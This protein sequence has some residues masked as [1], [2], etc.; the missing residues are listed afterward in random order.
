MIAF[1]MA[2]IVAVAGVLPL[3]VG[4]KIVA[5]VVTSA[6]FF[7]ILWP[8]FYAANPSLV[9]PLGGLLS[10]FLLLCWVTSAIVDSILDDELR[11][12]WLFAIGLLVIIIFRAGSGCSCFRASEYAKLIGDFEE[13]E[14]TQDVQPASAEHIRLVPWELA[15][16]LADKQLGEAPGAIGSQFSVDK[17]RATIQ[18]IRGEFWWVMPLDYNGFTVWTSVDNAPGYVLV[19]ADDPK[20][21]PILKYQ[22]KFVFTPGAYFGDNLE[23]HLWSNGYLAKGLDDAFLEIDEEG[24][25]WWVV[26]VFKPTIAYSGEKLLGIAMVDPENGN[27]SF[28]EKD[29]IPEWIDRAIPSQFIRYYI[30]KWGELRNGW[31]NSWWGTKDLMEA[32]PPEFVYGT[33]GEPYFVTR[34]TSTATGDEAVVGMFYTN[35][36]TGQTTKYHAVGATDAAILQVVDGKVEWKKWHGVS[37][38]IYNVYGVMTSVVPV[39]SKKHVFQGV[40]L[41][42]VENQ[43]AVVA[44]DL[45]SALRDYQ[46]LLAGSGNQI[47]PETAHNLTEEAGV[48]ERFAAEVKGGET[49]YYLKLVG[50]SRLYTGDSTN[51]AAPK[52]PLTKEGDEVVV[53]YISSGEDVVPMMRFD[54]KNLQLVATPAQEAVR[55]AGAERI[56]AAEVRKDAHDARSAI[57]EM[58]DEEVRD[59]MQQRGR[60]SDEPAPTNASSG[61]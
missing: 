57:N 59:L 9:W 26:A 39:L 38:T 7:V 43:Q 37:P 36:R 30:N 3:L 40:A 24:K 12:T 51:L 29:K 19:H 46:R 27:I 41:V 8:T 2:L 23:R 18:R 15:C 52:L 48:V 35:S 54:N 10:L 4:R 6:V 55:E 56:E 42:N 33:D 28:Y 20:V 58:S 49:I 16:F 17:N 11:L 13:K 21:P 53:N 31:L 1:I 61:E 45:T 47:A 32:E 34:I 44:G 14:W 5:A 50:Q 25:A 22:E 60:T